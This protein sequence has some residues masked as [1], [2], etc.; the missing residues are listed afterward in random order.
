[1]TI[2]ECDA[3]T[4]EFPGGCK[5]SSFLVLPDGKTSHFCSGS[6]IRAHVNR[7]PVPSRR[8]ERAIFYAAGIVAGLVA[9]FIVR[10]LGQ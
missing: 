6:C 7:L 3:C 4:R 8:K 5:G 1:V 2:Y 9:E 10:K